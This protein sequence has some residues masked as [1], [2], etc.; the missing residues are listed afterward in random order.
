MGHQLIAFAASGPPQD[1][2]DW[3]TECAEQQAN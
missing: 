2:P 1:Q 3:A